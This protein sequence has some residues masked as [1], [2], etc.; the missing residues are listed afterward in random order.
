MLMPRKIRNKNSLKISLLSV[1]FTAQ[2]RTFF[3]LLVH[4]SAVKNRTVEYYSKCTNKLSKTKKTTSATSKQP[5]NRLHFCN[6]SSAHFI[7]FNFRW[8]KPSFCRPLADVRGP[9]CP[10]TDSAQI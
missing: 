9:S 3:G 10:P 6:F 7:N 8:T 1:L 2:I 5:C 4:H